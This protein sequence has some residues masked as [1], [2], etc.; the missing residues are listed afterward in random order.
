MYVS[1]AYKEICNEINLPDIG[2]HGLRH[3][4]AT[5][6]VNAG[7]DYKIL[8]ERLGHESISMTMN[9][10]AHSL[11]EN[12]RNSLDNVVNFISNS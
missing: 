1:N 4:L 7:V 11:T 6:Y 12:K 9:V 2:L 5:L 10:Y 8:Q 3:T